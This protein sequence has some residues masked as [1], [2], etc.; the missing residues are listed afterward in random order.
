M[1][2]VRGL[3][4]ISQILHKDLPAERK[5]SRVFVFLQV[6]SGPS[7]QTVQSLWACCWTRGIYASC[8]QIKLLN[9]GEWALM[10]LS[11][12]TR[13]E[14]LELHFGLVRIRAASIGWYF[15]EVYKFGQKTL[16]NKF[17][18]SFPLMKPVSIHQQ[19][20]CQMKWTDL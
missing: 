17:R 8:N 6:S 1:K 2:R 15:F 7:V 14:M 19:V 11:W 18:A 9:C 13:W 4:V 12:L 16:K 3:A 5:S 20:H 10:G